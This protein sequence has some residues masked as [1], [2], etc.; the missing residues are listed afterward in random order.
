MVIIY[1]FPEGYFVIPNRSAYIDDETWEKVVKVVAPDIGKIRVSNV[2]FVLPIL[3][4]IYLTLHLFPSKLS[5]GYF[6][7]P[8]VVGIPHILWLQVSHECH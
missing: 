8:K 4:Y 3:F 2:A 7:F 1:G 5:S 6:S